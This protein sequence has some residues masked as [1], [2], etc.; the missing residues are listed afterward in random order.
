MM[1]WIHRAWTQDVTHDTI[2]NCWRHANIAPAAWFA[3]EVADVDEDVAVVQLQVELDELARSAQGRWDESDGVIAAENFVELDG[4]R[5]VHDLLDDAQIITMVST[6]GTEEPDSDEGGDPLPM[7]I[8]NSD[9]MSSVQKLDE[10]VMQH[11]ETFGVSLCHMFK[12]GHVSGQVNQ[13]RPYTLY[14]RYIR[15]FPYNLIHLDLNSLS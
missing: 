10:Y 15:I 6:Q 1:L 3:E 8:S 14:T 9:A 5:G 4:E 12:A 2:I 13:Y 7:P 11:A